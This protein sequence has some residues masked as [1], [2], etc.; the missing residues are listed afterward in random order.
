[1]RNASDCPVLVVAGGSLR[2]RFSVLFSGRG[3]GETNRLAVAGRGLRGS[4]FV[5]VWIGKNCCVGGFVARGFGSGFLER[6]RLGILVSLSSRGSRN[7]RCCCAGGSFLSSGSRS[8]LLSGSLSADGRARP[9][10][11]GV[12]GEHHKQGRFLKVRNRVHDEHKKVQARTHARERFLICNG[13]GRG[14]KSHTSAAVSSASLTANAAAA[15][16]CSFSAA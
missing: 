10:K 3:V 2:G 14:H 13:R 8:S 4:S 11:R 12:T 5:Y 6:R 7:S 16:V 1:V 9:K 15:S